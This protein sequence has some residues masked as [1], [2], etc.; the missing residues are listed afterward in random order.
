MPKLI[1][2]Y[3]GSQLKEYPLEEGELHIGRKPGNDICLDDLTVSG[4]HA[5][6]TISPNDYMEGLVDIHIEDLG[7]TNG[8]QVNGRPVR[9]QFLKHGDVVT[10]GTHEFTFIDENTLRFEETRIYLPDGR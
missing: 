5:L 4:S 10:I 9:R 3:S 7:S 2:S 1:H 6:L 8:T